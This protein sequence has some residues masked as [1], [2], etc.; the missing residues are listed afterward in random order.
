MRRGEG[1]DGGLKGRAMDGEREIERGRERGEDCGG[2]VDPWHSF[3]GVL[4]HIGGHLSTASG[5]IY[6]SSRCEW[7][8]RKPSTVYGNKL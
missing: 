2:L 3:D 1:R 4:R 5:E 7:D 8:H 6:E